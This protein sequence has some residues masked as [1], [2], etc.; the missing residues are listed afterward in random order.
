MTIQ[1]LIAGV[2]NANAPK[3]I[4][5]FTRNGEAMIVRSDGMIAAGAWHRYDGGREFYWTDRADGRGSWTDEA[6][7]KFLVAHFVAA[8]ERRLARR[9]RQ[10]AEPREG[11]DQKDA[12][13]LVDV[14]QRE[15]LI[16][17]VAAVDIR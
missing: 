1:D 16:E 5:S 7:D 4:K 15:A 9:L 14:T 6:V 8:N 17:R 2:L 3:F 11:V 12:R 10:L 13:A